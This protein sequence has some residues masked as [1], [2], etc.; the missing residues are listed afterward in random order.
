MFTWKSLPRPHTLL[1]L[2]AHGRLGR[3]SLCA[4][5]VVPAFYGSLAVYGLGPRALIPGPHE[6]MA[7]QPAT[8]EQRTRAAQ[9][10][11]DLE[12]VDAWSSARWRI[13]DDLIDQ[14][15]SL[16]QAADAMR[17]LGARVRE[18][19][20]EVRRATYPGSSDRASYARQ[21]IDHV[22]ARLCS[23]PHKAARVLARLQPEL[24]AL[25]TARTPANPRQS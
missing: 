15:L 14:H 10:D 23:Q 13:V 9:L 18:P 1:G 6:V 3:V 21:L 11:A 24:R 7:Q 2:G 4:A 17:D 20:P 22:Q 25:A 19:R 8:Q 16:R 5:V 12:R